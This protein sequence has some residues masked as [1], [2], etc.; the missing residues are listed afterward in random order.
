MRHNNAAPS[1]AQ[2]RWTL[3]DTLAVKSACARSASVASATILVFF[4]V[5]TIVFH[6][7]NLVLLYLALAAVLLSLPGISSTGSIANAVTLPIWLVSAAIMKLFFPELAAEEVVENAARRTRDLVIR[8]ASTTPVRWS[9]VG[10]V[11]LGGYSAA[12]DFL[13]AEPLASNAT[14]ADPLRLLDSVSLFIWDYDITPPVPMTPAL[15]RMLRA[16]H[17][18]KWT[19][20]VGGTAVALFADWYL[21]GDGLSFYTTPRRRLGR[22]LAVLGTAATLALDLDLHFRLCVVRGLALF[23]A[24]AVIAILSIAEVCS[25]ISADDLM[26]QWGLTFCKQA[27]S[28]PRDSHLHPIFY[29]EEYRDIVAVKRRIALAAAARPPGRFSIAVETEDETRER[30]RRGRLVVEQSLGVL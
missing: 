16:L 5:H 19:V 8:V 9:I 13:F 26:V 21:Y 30:M 25:A 27:E 14:A 12:S 7:W 11:L 29:R 3:A 20:L 4:V 28:Q 17:M 23:P 24:A 22:L 2:L 1:S 6:C 18:T 10:V 15:A